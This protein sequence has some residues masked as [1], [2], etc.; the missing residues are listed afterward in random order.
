MI[1]SNGKSSNKSKYQLFP[2][3]QFIDI[4]YLIINLFEF[5]K[6]KLPEILAPIAVKI[7]FFCSGIAAAKK[8]L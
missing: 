4:N 1:P 2:K 7:L 3:V 8:R 6:D 5:S